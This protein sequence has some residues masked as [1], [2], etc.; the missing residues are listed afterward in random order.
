MMLSA[1]TDYYHHQIDIAIII[2]STFIYNYLH[3]NH[4]FIINETF[5]I[6]TNI[7]SFLYHTCFFH[8]MSKQYLKLYILIKCFQYSLLYQSF[9]LY[10]TTE[11]T[12]CHPL[13]GYITFLSDL[14]LVSKETLFAPRKV[15]PLQC[16]SGKAPLSSQL[17]CPSLQSALHAAGDRGMSMIIIVIVYNDNDD[18]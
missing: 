5:A 4:I 17:S 14:H 12:L 7:S 2:D 18:R 3:N 16:S 8:S 6:V 11:V 13:W 9:I 1:V 10:I 15:P